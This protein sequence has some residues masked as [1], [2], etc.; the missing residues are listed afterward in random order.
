[1]DEL[2]EK[3]KKLVLNNINGNLDKDT[4]TALS[5]AILALYLTDG[6]IIL[7]KM[8]T[9]LRNLDIRIK[10]KSVVELAHEIGLYNNDNIYKNALG[11]T[12]TQMNVSIK[13][14]IPTISFQYHLLV[15][16][17]G[18]KDIEVTNTVVHEL[19][20]LLRKISPKIEPS[21]ITIYNGVSADYI[22]IKERKITRAC[23]WFEDALVEYHAKKTTCNLMSLVKDEQLTSELKAFNKE[24][25]QYQDDP[26]S[27]YK[28]FNFILDTLCKD[29]ILQEKLDATFQNPSLE[30]YNSLATYINETNKE[31]DFFS[32]YANL[33]NQ[34]GTSYATNDTTNRKNI[35]E[36]LLSM[37]EQ[38]LTSKNSKGL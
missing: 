34:L 6:K 33:F 8:P 5:T 1:M 18:R 15:S 3:C 25:Q 20:H 17:R 35:E 37:T 29:Q 2:F 22:D 4:I 32:K 10:P 11:A 21:K 28:F 16:L 27:P 24:N 31:K 14:N 36:S 7:E 19:T 9:I 13:E 38:F 26:E 30:T 23:L 12:N